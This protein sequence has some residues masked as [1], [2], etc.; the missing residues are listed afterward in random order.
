MMRL[1][2]IFLALAATYLVV[3]MVLGIG[4]FRALA[5]RPCRDTASGHSR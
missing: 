1:D 5:R 4:V 3:G 2:A